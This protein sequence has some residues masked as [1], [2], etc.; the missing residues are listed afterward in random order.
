M[1]RTV[2]VLVAFCIIL[3]STVLVF[4]SETNVKAYGN[5]E[6]GESYSTVKRKAEQDS[7]MY[8][9][10]GF[11]EKPLVV[12]DIVITDYGA[13][14]HF[15]FFKDQLYQVKINSKDQTANYFDSIIK[16]FQKVL[17]KIMTK[18]Y[19]PATKSKDIGFADLKKGFIKWSHL[20][21]PGDIGVEKEIKIGIHSYAHAS[22][23]R[24]IM[25]INYPPLNEKRKQIEKAED[26]NSIAEESE[27]F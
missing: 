24:V 4:A 15:S 19:G 17:V 10:G 11:P 14:I 22:E 12:G 16:P 1:K 7:D 5:I 20:W 23:Y 21:E 25:L 2:V 8:Y 3:P 26:E 27:N 18:N 6:F 9:V 13:G